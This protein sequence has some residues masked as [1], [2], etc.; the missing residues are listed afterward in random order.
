MLAVLPLIAAILVPLR[1]G[2]QCQRLSSTAA[3]NVIENDIA[4]LTRSLLVDVVEVLHHSCCCRICVAI[5]LVR[6]GLV[7][8][9][10]QVLIFGLQ[11]LVV[12]SNSLIRGAFLVAYLFVCLRGPASCSCSRA[13][14]PFG[15][16]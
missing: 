8:P 9:S 1:G 16:N 15:W 7:E 12:G 2:V 10:S 3:S 11:P 4:H 13:G 14:L 6:V 5:D